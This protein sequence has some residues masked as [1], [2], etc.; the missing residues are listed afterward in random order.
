MRQ[1]QFSTNHNLSNIYKYLLT[2]KKSTISEATLD[3]GQPH[4]VSWNVKRTKSEVFF[5]CFFFLPI[6]PHFIF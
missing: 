5:C 6:V 4:P 2:V 1:T 3:L